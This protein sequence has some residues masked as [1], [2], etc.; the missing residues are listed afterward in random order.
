MCWIRDHN[1]NMED[2]GLNSWKTTCEIIGCE[3]D[4]FFVDPNFE[5][6]NIQLIDL[7]ALI[8]KHETYH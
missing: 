2:F 5:A 7:E 8:S 4:G 1:K 6:L 3:S